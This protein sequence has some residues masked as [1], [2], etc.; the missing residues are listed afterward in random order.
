MSNGSA[1]AWDGS[2]LTSYS[3]GDKTWSAG[4]PAEDNIMKI[5]KIEMYYNRTGSTGTCT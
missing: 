2:R 3:N 4:P 5:S 1:T